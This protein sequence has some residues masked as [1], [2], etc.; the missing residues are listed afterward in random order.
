MLGFSE[1]GNSEQATYETSE[2]YQNTGVEWGH[3]L[4]GLDQWTRRTKDG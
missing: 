2:K 4:E 1:G 3:T